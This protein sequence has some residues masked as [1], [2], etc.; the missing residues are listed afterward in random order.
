MIIPLIRADNL[1]KSASLP[2]LVETVGRWSLFGKVVVAGIDDWPQSDLE[3]LARQTGGS[4]ELQISR[5]DRDAHSL[6]E[7]LNHGASQIVGLG[8]TQDGYDCPPGVPLE[9]W[10]PLQAEDADSLQRGQQTWLAEPAPER[11]AELDRMGVDGLVDIEL[12]EQRPE[13]IATFFQQ[14][15]TSDRPDGLWPT[16]IVDELGLALGL[17]YSN[18]ESLLDAI[19]NR[20]GTYWSRSRGGLWVKGLNSGNTQRLLGVR[21]DCDRDCLRFQVAQSGAGFCHLNT[22]SCFGYERTIATVIGRLQQRCRSADEGSF[23]KKLV[24][25]PVMLKTKLLEE[26]TELSEAR[27]Q[28]EAAFEAADV[29][30]FSLV[31]MLAVGAELSEVYQELARRMTRVIRRKNKLES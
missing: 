26:A 13:L 23:T 16:L 17:A 4:V 21:L 10:Q 2:R 14:A 31:K 15:L 9:S 12:L 7:L 24:D 8:G 30:Y 22:Y 28:E 18:Y 6:I 27:T 11:L 19:T 3:Q 1:S 20:R 29:L 25:D 5:G